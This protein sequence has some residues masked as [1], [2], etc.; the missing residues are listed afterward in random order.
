MKHRYAAFPQPEKSDDVVVGG[1]VIEPEQCVKGLIKNAF[2]PSLS[3]KLQIR[4]LAWRLRALSVWSRSQGQE[5]DSQQ[6]KHRDSKATTGAPASKTDH[7]ESHWR[8][9]LT[10]NV[11]SDHFVFD[12][13]H[14]PSDVYRY[15]KV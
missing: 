13:G 14:L 6:K 11:V 9:R 12:K 5:E 7:P 8:S 2:V 1:H 4:C 10:L 15:I 3:C